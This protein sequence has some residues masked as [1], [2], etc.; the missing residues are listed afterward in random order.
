MP[1]IK[2]KTELLKKLE[3]MKIKSAE[4]KARVVCAIIGHSRIVSMCFGYVSCSRCQDQIGD[5]LAS[6]FDLDKCV[7]VGH[8]CTKCQANLKKMTWRDRFLAHENP[9]A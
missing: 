8:N 2:T 9:L 3:S 4:K 5:T 6:S 7:V 1:E